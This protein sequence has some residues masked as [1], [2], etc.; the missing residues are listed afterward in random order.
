MIY[1]SLV[2]SAAL[3][4]V[5]H[6]THHPHNIRPRGGEWGI[7]LSVSKQRVGE[8]GTGAVAGWLLDFWGQLHM[9]LCIFT[10]TPPL[11]HTR[12]AANPS[13]APKPRRLVCRLC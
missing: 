13:S 9:L 5:S 11:H 7:S 3:A 10:G 1:A 12:E 6:H 2:S 8:M 4:L